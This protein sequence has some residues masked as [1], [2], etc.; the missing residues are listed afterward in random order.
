MVG[1]EMEAKQ[2]ALLSLTLDEFEYQLNRMLDEIQ[3]RS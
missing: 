1:G 2:K 3:S